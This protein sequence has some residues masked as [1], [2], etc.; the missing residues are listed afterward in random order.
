MGLAVLAC[1]S[2]RGQLRMVN[3]PAQRSHDAQEPSALAPRPR[4]RRAP[5]NVLLKYSNA[6]SQPA[7]MASAF[8]RNA[9]WF[10]GARDNPSRPAGP[11]SFSDLAAMWAA[12]RFNEESIV[13][14]EGMAVQT[15]VAD[16]HGL[17]GALRQAAET[18]KKTGATPS[19]YSPLKPKTEPSPSFARR[20]TF[21][22]ALHKLHAGN[23]GAQPPAGPVSATVPQGLPAPQQETAGLSVDVPDPNSTSPIAEP[24]WWKQ[25]GAGVDQL[26]MATTLPPPSSQLPAHRLPPPQTGAVPYSSSEAGPIPP[27]QS[28]RWTVVRSGKVAEPVSFAGLARQWQRGEVGPRTVLW[29]DAVANDTTATLAEKHATTLGSYPGLVTTLD[30]APPS[31]VASDESPPERKKKSAVPPKPNVF[32]HSVDEPAA[33]GSATSL[34]SVERARTKQAQEIAR[35]LKKTLESRESELHNLRSELTD[36]RASA[37]VASHAEVSSLRQSNADLTNASAELARVRQENEDLRKAGAIAAAK[38]DA[39]HT[40]LADLSPTKGGGTSS[41]TELDIEVTKLRGSLKTAETRVLKLEEQLDVAR[42]EH[43]DQVAELRR[44]HDERV[45]SLRDKADEEMRAARDLSAVSNNAD[46]Q[47]VAAL[48]EAARDRADAAIASTRAEAER[49]VQAARAR[50]EEEVRRAR[51]ESSAEVARARDEAVRDVAAARERAEAAASGSAS[52]NEAMRQMHED[53]ARQLSQA[54]ADFDADATALREAARRDI[55]RFMEERDREV[56][57]LREQLE[58]AQSDAT[59]QVARA[60]VLADQ[61]AEEV[62]VEYEDRLAAMRTDQE[63]R[64]HATSES[65]SRTLDESEHRHR[66]DREELMRKLATAEEALV[67]EREEGARRAAELES[68]MRRRGTETEAEMRRR[69]TLAA[70]E[71][72]RKVSAFA[73][74]C[75][76]RLAEAARDH[77]RRVA[78]AEEIAKGAV[79]EANRRAATAADEA[80]RRVALTE[81]TRDEALAKAKEALEAEAMRVK[82]ECARVNE[83]YRSEAQRELDEAREAALDEAG[84]RVAAA[85]AEASSARADASAARETLAAEVQRIS[86]EAGQRE[87]ALRVEADERVA[88]ASDGAKREVPELRRQVQALQMELNRLARENERLRESEDLLASRL[89]KPGAGSLQAKLEAA[90]SE[91]QALRRENTAVKAKLQQEERARAI[92]TDSMDE[93]LLDISG[94]YSSGATPSSGSHRNSIAAPLDLDG[95]EREAEM[96][97]A[98]SAHRIGGGERSSVESEL[99][100]PDDDGPEQQMDRW[101]VAAHTAKQIIPSPPPPLAMP[102]R[103][104]RSRTMRAVERNMPAEETERIEQERVESAVELIL[105]RFEASGVFLPIEQVQG[106]CYSVASR[107]VHLKVL[108]GRLCVR[109]GGGYQDFLEWLSRARLRKS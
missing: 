89:P 66:L 102:Q 76:R 43:A 22:D 39:A 13:W 23:T 84:S 67:R 85:E 80:D 54:R 3:G 32:A 30:M 38:L 96:I 72:E 15:R 68:E 26:G 34:L 82:A 35:A 78:D 29:S 24:A 87:H 16:V 101:D 88:A 31:S 74:S 20:H 104:E 70:E 42:R 33:N 49:E 65:A 60:R 71:H 11:V 73:E 55:N 19:A 64:S 103:R 86:S 79:D 109:S 18:A 107:R 6:T 100:E 57:Q 50:A 2:A 81:A 28:M 91:V 1:G 44:S 7:A 77:E 59:K 99:Y 52:T 95:F 37:E 45:G 17:A 14:A 108:S 58:E 48:I 75:D 56:R 27:Y 53:H 92:L 5:P 97:Q 9:S 41:A 25:N 94:G 40:K 106:C 83:A 69:L 46:K 47:H 61:L 21:V 10:Y 63:R 90:K 36:L 8:F 4:P 93:P 51:D 98:R 12:E 62:R 105:Q